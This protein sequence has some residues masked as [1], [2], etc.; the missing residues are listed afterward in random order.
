MLSQHAGGFPLDLDGIGKR[1]EYV[2]EFQEKG[3]ARLDPAL[4]CLDF[5]G[6]P[7]GE[8]ARGGLVQDREN[9]QDPAPLPSDGS[10][11]D[12]EPSTI[13]RQ[14]PARRMGLVAHLN[15][16]AREGCGQLSFER[17]SG[18]GFESGEAERVAGPWAD[19]PVIGVVVEKDGLLAPCE[20]HHSF[21][22]EHQVHD[23]PEAPWPVLDPAKA[24]AGP[25]VP[26][27]ALGHLAAGEGPCVSG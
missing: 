19:E 15:R 13:E 7:L 1:A 3:L 12:V 2:G 8:N 24:R 26:T 6:S 10:V 11:G 21:T 27:D 22:C 9:A 18:H 25:V 23:R 17:L 14:W 16:A 5:L 4:R 20:G